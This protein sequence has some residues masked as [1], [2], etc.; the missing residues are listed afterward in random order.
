MKPNEKSEELLS[1]TEVANMHGVTRPCINFA[2]LDGRLPATKVGRIWV[3]RRSD[4]E[5]W[6]ARP[7]S[8]APVRRAFYPRV[9]RLAQEE[10]S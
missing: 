9:K 8:R 3:V 6:A 4:A 7:Y 2:I 10:Q 1:V 5:A